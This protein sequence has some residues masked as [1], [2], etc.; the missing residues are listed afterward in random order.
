MLVFACATA[1]LLAGFYVFTPLFR[2]SKGSLEAE[3]L[4]VTDMDRLLDRKAAIYGNLKDLE[5]EY[6]MGRLSE[7]DFAGLEADYKKEA[8]AILQQLDRLGAEIDIDEAPVKQGPA[9]NIPGA[10]RCPSCGAEVLTGKKFC[11][12]CGHRL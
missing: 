3:L 4:T 9:R 2:E 1:V 10:A 12:D 8:A 11:A 7:T 6:G 5:F